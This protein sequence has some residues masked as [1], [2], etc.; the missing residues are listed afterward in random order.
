MYSFER[1]GVPLLSAPVWAA[2]YKPSGLFWRAPRMR[3]LRACLKKMTAE[4]G[5]SSRQCGTTLSWPPKSSLEAGNTS[6]TDGETEAKSL[7]S[8]ECILCNSKSTFACP[9]TSLGTLLYLQMG[10]QPFFS[11]KEGAI[12]LGSPAA[13]V[14]MV[15]C[16]PSDSDSPMNL[17]LGDSRQKRN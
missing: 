7:S 12:S 10:K 8:S 9:W 6:I 4:R 16:F 17:G 14:Y 5:H 15:Q 11:P 2:G 13:D 3:G 1:L